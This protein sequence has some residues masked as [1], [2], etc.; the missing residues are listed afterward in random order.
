MQL[1]NGEVTGRPTPVG[2]LPTKEE[3][4][5]DGL[6]IDPADLDRLL[7]IDVDRWRQEMDFRQKHL[8][9]FDG[10]PEEIWEA[11]RRV[12]AALADEAG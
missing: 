11:H 5:L 8:E 6:E 4:N 3:L 9:Q 1:K 10:L 2:V 12:A 7:T